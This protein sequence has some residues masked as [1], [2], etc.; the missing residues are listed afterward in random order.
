VGLA[1]QK[2][3]AQKEKSPNER[4]EKNQATIRKKMTLD[5]DQ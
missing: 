4:E 2:S 3:T 1:K 5:S